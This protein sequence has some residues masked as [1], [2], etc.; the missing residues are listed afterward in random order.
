MPLHEYL[1]L[2][3]QEYGWVA[4]K[5]ALLPVLLFAKK[6]GLSMR[7]VLSF[8]AGQVGAARSKPSSSPQ[9]L[10]QWIDQDRRPRRRARAG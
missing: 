7:E 5:P 9:R 2:T 1:G 8:S 10:L 3:L 4:A 6:A